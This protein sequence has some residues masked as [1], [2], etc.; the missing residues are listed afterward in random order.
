MLIE[1]RINESIAVKQRIL[2]DKNIINTIEKISKVIK[3]AFENNGKVLLCGNGG[4]A[5]DS[6]HLASEFTGR[7]QRNRKSLPAISLNA[8]I[9]ELTSIANDYGY[10]T[11]FARTVE[12]LMRPE[13]VLM[14][15]S[16]SG[17][18]ENIYQAVMKAKEIGATT[19]VLLGKT[20]GKIMEQ[21][22]YN[23]IVPSDCTARIQESHIMIGH[24]ICEMVEEQCTSCLG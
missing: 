6:L 21:A 19:I 3:R 11:V 20:G 22:D 12:G 1:D 2:Q 24:I 9:S 8:N 14:G 23:I 5:A 4:S 17:N 15:I 16:T 18:S 7:F 10:D 13:D